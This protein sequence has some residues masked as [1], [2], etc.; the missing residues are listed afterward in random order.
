MKIVDRKTFLAMP[1]NTVFSKFKPC[2]FEQ[3][4]IKEN[5]FEDDFYFYSISSDAIDAD[6]DDFSD[7]LMVNP[8]GTS[9]KMDFDVLSRDGCFDENQLFAVWEKQDIKD[10]ISKLEKCIK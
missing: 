5:T 10:L 9:L 2:I 6:G 8:L 4:C 7:K 1:E 3:V